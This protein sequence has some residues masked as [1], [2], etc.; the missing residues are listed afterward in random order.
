VSPQGVAVTAR[1]TAAGRAV[2]SRRADRLFEDPLAAALAGDEGF[3]L[4]KE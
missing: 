3:A 1:L 4:M 2:E